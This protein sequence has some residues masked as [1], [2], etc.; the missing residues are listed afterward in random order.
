MEIEASGFLARKSPLQWAKE[1]WPIIS[2]SAIV[3]AVTLSVFS[4]CCFWWVFDINF[5]RYISVSD[6][7]H[8]SLILFGVNIPFASLGLILFLFTFRSRREIEF[9]YFL[10]SIMGILAGITDYFKQDPNHLRLS[11]GV[12]S[13]ICILLTIALC[14]KPRE[15]LFEISLRKPVASY[16]I[17]LTGF[18][19]SHRISD[20]LDIINGTRYDEVFNVAFV[21]NMA[22]DTII[23]LRYIGRLGDNIFLCP[24]ADYKDIVIVNAE[25]VNFIAI[26]RY[27]SHSGENRRRE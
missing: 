5:T 2:A 15:I 22:P 23:G 21:N 8:E 19:A 7:V 24:S 14:L 20:A 26:G 27:T 13:T 16:V 6:V 17:I 4:S 9:A 11:T 12:F 10:P 1:Y 18:V 3:V 25:E